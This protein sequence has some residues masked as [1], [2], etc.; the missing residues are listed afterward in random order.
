MAFHLQK[1]VV[2]TSLN[3]NNVKRKNI[4]TFQNEMT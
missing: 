3:Q 1:N 4:K 2:K